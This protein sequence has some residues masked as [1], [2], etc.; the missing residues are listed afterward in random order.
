MTAPATDK[1][2]RRPPPAAAKSAPSVLQGMRGLRPEQVAFLGEY[3]ASTAGKRIDVQILCWP[4]V[5]A[6]WSMLAQSLGGLQSLRQG[7][8]PATQRVPVA[9]T[10]VQQVAPQLCLPVDREPTA[11]ESTLA[12]LIRRL[13]LR[14]AV[15]VV[16]QQGTQNAAPDSV[17]YRSLFSGCLTAYDAYL[18]S[19]K[20]TA[21]RVIIATPGDAASNDVRRATYGD[22]LVHLDSTERLG[23]LELGFWPEDAVPLPMEVAQLAAAAVG[24][25]LQHPSTASPLFETVRAHLVPPSR[26]HALSRQKRRK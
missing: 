6:A 24:Q 7:D 2:T 15:A 20:Q 19:T 9:T 5:S 3:H 10:W 26:F 12:T 1:R 11:V 23:A 16:E 17:R 22:A 13:P 21:C 18:K 4:T 8:H 25:H 14:F